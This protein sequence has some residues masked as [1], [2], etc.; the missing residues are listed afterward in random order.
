MKIFLTGSTGFIG[1]HLLRLALAAGHEVTALRRPGSRPSIPIGGEPRWLEKPLDML[2][3]EDLSGHDA[4]LHLASIGVSPKVA[5]WEEMFYWN[6][7]VMVRLL[8]RC[9]S[10]NVPR[11]VITG[12]FAEYGRSSEQYEYIPADAPLQPTSAYA[13]SK[14]AGSIA[15]Y[16]YAIEHKL[17]LCYLRI[18]SAFGEGQY[19][20]NFWPAL[21]HAALSGADFPMTPGEQ[22]RDY[23]PVERV[24]AKLLGYAATARHG[25]DAPFVANLGSGAP[26]TMYQFARHWWEHWHAKGKLC[27]GVY[28]YRPNEPMRY[29]PQLSPEE[30]A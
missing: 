27:P 25:K 29:V 19:E 13:A 10:A 23:I 30:R 21:R 14:A 26:V 11:T 7:S 1:S 15:A 16:T 22:I 9:R 24:A 5:S 12:T 6:V 18:F 2:E 17:E 3:A 4:I 28:P 8:E 20:K